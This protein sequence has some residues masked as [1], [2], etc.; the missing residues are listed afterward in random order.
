ML[1]KQRKTISILHF[2]KWY[3]ST[4]LINWRKTAKNKS[5]EENKVEVE[6]LEENMKN[7]RLV[8]SN[9]EE[10]E[11]ESDN[12]MIEKRN[13]NKILMNKSDDTIQNEE[14]SGYNGND[15]FVS[16]DENS[17]DEQLIQ[18]V[19]LSFIQLLINSIETF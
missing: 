19:K 4:A 3:I 12:E 5:N 16:Y 2:I 8:K 6:Q 17:D 1:G 15:N 10:D 11:D 13:Q 14:E 18:L 9:H 7:I